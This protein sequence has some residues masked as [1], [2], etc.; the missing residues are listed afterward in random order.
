MSKLERYEELIE[1]IRINLNDDKRFANTLKFVRDKTEHY[2]SV[3]KMDKTDILE[4]IEKNRTYWAANYYQ[5]SKLPTI[6]ATVMIYE[7]SAEMRADIK[8]EL[9]FVC[10]SC[11]GIS[12]DPNACN[13]GKETSTGKICDW[14]TY[15]LFRSHNIYRCII[16]ETF[17]ESATVYEIFMP[18]SKQ[19]AAGGK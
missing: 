17:L 11:G 19:N 2:A 8:P 6:D 3:L 13:S 14:K 15:G 9:G 1:S 12:M 16:K 7:T 5:E 10:S 18:V 4:A